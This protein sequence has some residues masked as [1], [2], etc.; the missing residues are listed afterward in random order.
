MFTEEDRK[1]LKFLMDSNNIKI[2]V[3][4]GFTNDQKIK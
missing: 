4:I 1:D 3:R 2:Q